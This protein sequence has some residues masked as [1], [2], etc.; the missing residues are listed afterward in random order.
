[1]YMCVKFPIGDLNPD[2]YPPHPTNVYICG[3]TTA[4]RVRD[5]K[6]KIFK[7]LPNVSL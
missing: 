2:P 1:M 5:G 3:V 6:C 4:P 7:A